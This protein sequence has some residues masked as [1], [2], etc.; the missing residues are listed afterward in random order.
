MRPE[1]G[2]LRALF[3]RAARPWDHTYLAL[4]AGLVD[5]LVNLV[6]RDARSQGGGSNVQDFSRQAAHLAHAILGLGVEDLDLVRPSERAAGLGDTVG[7]VVRVGDR[8]GDG[9]LL[10]Q[11]V[12]GSQGAGVGEGG[13]GVVVSGFWIRFRYYFWRN[14]VVQNTVF[15]LVH[16]LMRA[17]DQRR[18]S[19]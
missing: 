2:P 8:L 17:L 15:L 11:R 10:G 6:G 4:D 18:G 3:P 14:E 7:S 19:R 9:A 5:D 13:E 16:R 1:R 12:D